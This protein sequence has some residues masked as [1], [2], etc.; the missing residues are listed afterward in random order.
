MLNV[1]SRSGNHGHLG[2]LAGPLVEVD[3]KEEQ[4]NAGIKAQ[5]A[6]LGNLY[7]WENAIE[8]IVQVNTVR[9]IIVHKLSRLQ[10]WRFILSYNICL[11]FLTIL[12]RTITL[13]NGVHGVPVLG[14]ALCR[15]KNKSISHKGKK[16]NV[17]HWIL[18]KAWIMDMGRLVQ[19]WKQIW[20]YTSKRKRVSCRNV[21][22]CI[23]SPYFGDLR[24]QNGYSYIDWE[25]LYHWHCIL[26]W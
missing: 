18:M 16:D 3:I 25:C 4:E 15:T 2:Q 24:Q 9:I 1:N 6:V 17:H 21:K 26:M 7:K 8:L 10:Y 13:I 22:V 11:T 14:H 12:Q 23:K 5:Q 20:I 19:P